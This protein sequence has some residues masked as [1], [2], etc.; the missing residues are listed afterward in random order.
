VRRIAAA[1]GQLIFAA[2]HLGK[3]RLGHPGL[4]SAVGDAFNESASYLVYTI[5]R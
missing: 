2:G 3:L 5:V 1:R 4:E